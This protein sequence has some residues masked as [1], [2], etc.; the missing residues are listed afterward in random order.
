MP[1]S[2]ADLFDGIP[3]QGLLPTHRQIVIDGIAC[4]SRQVEPNNVF[5]AL[6]GHNTDGRLFIADAIARGAVAIVSAVPSDPT[7][8]R[9]IQNIP[10]IHVPDPRAPLPTLAQRAY[11]FPAKKL[12]LHA[13]TGTNG[14]TTTVYM[15]AAILAQ[16]GHR[17]AFWTTNSV[18]GIAKPF[19]PSMT[20]PDAPQLHRF[21]REALDRG[22][23]DVIIEVSS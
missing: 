3:C 16:A 18:E 13:V 2:L 5:V 7:A 4:D 10:W 23:Q 8:H 15:L 21:L 12:R 11:G 14:K 1:C 17:V 9:T 20:T 6:Q 22:A 19:R